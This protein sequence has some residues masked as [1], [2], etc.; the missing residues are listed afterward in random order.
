MR[1][2][3]WILMAA[4]LFSHVAQ[5]TIL[6]V[7]GEDIDF[8]NGGSVCTAGSYVRSG[9]N[10]VTIYACNA[11][12]P[13]ISNPFPGGAITS[14]WLSA[15]IVIADAAGLKYVGFTKSGTNSSLWIGTSGSANTKLALYKFDGT[16]WTE[17]A[18]EST[19]SLTYDAQTKIDMQVINYGAS[20]TV[21]MY[22]NGGATPRITYTGNV[23]AGAATNLDSVILRAAGGWSMVSEVI[24]SDSDT[25]TMSLVTLAPN[26]A[27]TTNQW[28]GTYSN[29][30]PTTINNAVNITDGTSG[31]TFQCKMNSLPT[32]NFSILGV[33]VAAFGLKTT[34]GPGSLAVGVYTNSSASVPAAVG[35]QTTW[36]PTVETLYSTNPV[37]SSA[38][39]SSEINSLQ[40]NLQTAP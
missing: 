33:K 29:I 20:A 19:G 17:I 15:Q 35:L 4:F 39:T 7:G 14:A 34:T 9:Y 12:L 31:D 38:W 30:N 23:V 3:K 5:A 24:V 11:N 6:W 22:V 21:N 37:T 13:A 2:T 26:A 16:T 25:R 36:G 32:G 18:T 27:G 8:P 10:R 1:T 40:M 28:T